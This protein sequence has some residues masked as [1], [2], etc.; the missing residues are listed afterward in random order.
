MGV[1]ACFRSGCESI[2]CDLYSDRYGYICFDCFDEL[3][4][5]G[6]KTDIAEFMDSKKNYNDSNEARARYNA[7]FKVD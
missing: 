4:N 1:K 6:A 2:M 7:V 3:I 5:S